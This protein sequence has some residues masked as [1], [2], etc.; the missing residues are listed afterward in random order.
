MVYIFD[1]I[2]LF[3]DS[4]YKKYTSL[5]SK[6]RREKRDSFVNYSDRIISMLSYLLLRYALYVEYDIL[7][8]P[9]FRYGRGNKPY[10]DMNI[11]FNLSHCK[12]AVMCGISVNEIG[13]D[14]QDDIE[15]VQNIY[16]MVCSEAEKAELSADN[17][18]R[19][20]ADF[21]TLKESLGKMLSCGI[22]YNLKD[23]SFDCMLYG[24]NDRF[25]YS[26]FCGRKDDY[27]YSVCSECKTDIK[28][29]QYG[30]LKVF[31]EKLFGAE[32]TN[33]L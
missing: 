25:G 26:F 20:F 16:D 11:H 28:F 8:I 22:I 9:Y 1:E 15:S 23:Y 13:I 7:K 3:T 17:S 4:D 24:W 32:Q 5:L 10:I 12:K 31:L 18:G 14:I 27:S 2:S 21:W 6:E 19:R 29:I 33:I 30:E